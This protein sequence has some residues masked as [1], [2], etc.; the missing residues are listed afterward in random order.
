MG[1]LFFGVRTLKKNTFVFYSVYEFDLV[2]IASV[3]IYILTRERKE[4]SENTTS[5][6]TYFFFFTTINLAHMI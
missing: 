2:N 6:L 3:A 4:K 1:T 5:A